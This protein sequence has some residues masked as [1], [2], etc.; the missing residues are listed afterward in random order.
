MDP[1]RTG[2]EPTLQGVQTLASELP[3]WVRAVAGL[4]L[5]PLAFA[6]G[7]AVVWVA[8]AV[9]SLGGRRVV[10]AHWTQRA[11]LY[12]PARLLAR[13]AAPTVGITAGSAAAFSAGPLAVLPAPLLGFAVG[14]AGY[15]G[16]ALAAERL[17]RRATG[18]R[19][20]VL[21]AVRGDL[22][23]VLVLVPQ[24]PILVAMDL[25][26]GPAWSAA[27]LVAAVA[28]TLL[29][30]V[31]SVWGGLPAARSL[32]LLRPASPRVQAAVDR[33]AQRCGVVPRAVLEIDLPMANAIAI[34][35]L[36]WMIFTTRGT[37]GLDDAELEAVSGHELGHLAEPRSVVAAR[38]AA[39]F[40]LL[41]L[42]FAVLWIGAVGP[43]YGL[44]ATYLLVLGLALPLARMRVALE[45]RADTHAHAYG[46]EPRTFARALE[47]MQER[48]LVPAVGF[49]AK[50]TT[51]PPLHDRLRAAGIE[52]DH[53]RPAPP[54]RLRLLL[55]AVAGVTALFAA[56][57]LAATGAGIAAAAAGDREGRA[58]VSIAASGG[59]D[60]DL[61]DLA[62]AWSE[63][64]PAVAL[65]A[66]DD[67]IAR[68]PTT[69]H[70]LALR[71][72]ILAR[73]GRCGEAARDYGAAVGSLADW[74]GHIEQC[75]WIGRAVEALGSCYGRA[76]TLDPAFR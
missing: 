24:L 46:G 57:S 47:R 43:L 26:V 1:D 31:A 15:A 40:S 42:G 76:A 64:R 4:P 51:H 72:A 61:F 67:V 5:V 60:R 32:G 38:V 53:P 63:D 30:A 28:G 23:M 66:L 29:Y 8:T 18:E 6:G 48:N 71:S 75:P 62:A 69:H 49:S 22:L 35:T 3:V 55:G 17:A 33:V 13:L 41:P 50:G 7:A 10:H 44:A 52:P 37:D 68:R 27:T 39:S 11:R 16:G 58:L 14:L 21:R 2:T 54:S 45:K 73:A 19:R 56:T 59:T 36:Q 70:A 12:W 74:T 65:A 34:P 20:G 9:A 25:T